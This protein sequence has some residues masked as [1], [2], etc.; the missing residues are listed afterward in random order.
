MALVCCER[1]EYIY[2]ACNVSMAAQISVAKP[3][4]RSCRRATTSSSDTFEDKKS[5]VKGRTKY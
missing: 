3:P 5:V 2:S 4:K 1:R